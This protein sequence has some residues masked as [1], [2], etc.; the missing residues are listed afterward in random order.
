M[1]KPN[2]IQSPYISTLINTCAIPIVRF[3][4]TNNNLP[5]NILRYVDVERMDRICT[6]CNLGDT[7]DEFHYIFI[8]PFFTLKI[9]TQD[10]G[11]PMRAFLKTSI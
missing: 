10:Y 8:C 9:N 7:G 5:V 4:T 1:I 11:N 6:K 3:I 2:F